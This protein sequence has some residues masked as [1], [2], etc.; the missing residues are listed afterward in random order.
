MIDD[1]PKRVNDVIG[2][3]GNNAKTSRPHVGIGKSHISVPFLFPYHT[4]NRIKNQ[5][6]VIF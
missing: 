2:Q 1:I 5:E 4:A 6:K 3:A